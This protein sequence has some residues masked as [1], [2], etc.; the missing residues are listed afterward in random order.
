MSWLLWKINNIKSKFQNVFCYNFLLSA[1]QVSLNCFDLV[2]VIV[3]A[4]VS[5][6]SEQIKECR[7]SFWCY[8]RLWAH[9]THKVPSKICGRW[10]SYLF[11]LFSEKPS[12]DISCE[13]SAWQTIHIKCQDLFSLAKKKKS[14]LLST[15][16]VIGSL[17][18]NWYRGELLKKNTPELHLTLKA[19]IATAVETILLLFFQRIKSWHFMWIISQADSHETP[20]LIFSEN[21]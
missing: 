14:K 15:A 1:L 18:V 3:N 20:R 4:L 2:A 8:P 19:A 7:N 16:I 9:L 5:N 6:M 12:L 17:R 10:Q 11:F 21:K 13:L